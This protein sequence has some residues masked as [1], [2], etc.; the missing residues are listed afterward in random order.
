[1]LK[2]AINIM[3]Q[4]IR[5]NRIYFKNLLFKKNNPHEFFFISKISLLNGTWKKSLKIPKG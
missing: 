2:V 5:L 4:H 3:K 1:M